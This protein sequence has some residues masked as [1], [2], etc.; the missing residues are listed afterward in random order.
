M[1]LTA[2]TI[3]GSVQTSVLGATAMNSR[4]RFCAALNHIE[5][6]R[7]PVDFGATSVTGMHVLAVTRLRLAVTGDGQYRVKVT[8]PYQMLGELDDVL[9]D[10]LEIDV[11]GLPT[12]KNMFGMENRGWKPFTL[13][14]GTEVLVPEDFNVRKDERGDL[15][16]FPE[17]DTNAPPS[18][19][20][21]K[22][23][24][25]FDT[26][27]RQPP[28]VE[29]RLDPNDN[30]EEFALISDQDLAW[31]TQLAE[32]LD[33][34]CRRGVILTMP[35]AAFGDIA[36]VPA[37]WMKHPKGIRDVAE[38]YIS[39]AIRRDYVLK[40]FEKQCEIALKNIE[41]LIA[42]LGD[43]VQAVM[44]TGTDFGT[45]H[46]LFLSIRDYRELFKPF[47]VRV[48]R[49]IHDRS[50]WKTF[51]HSCG[52][53][54]QLIPEFIEAGFDILN[55]VQCSATGMDAITLKREFGKQIVFWGGGVNTQ[56][57]MAF[58]TPDEVYREARQRIEIFGAGGGFVFNSV[59]NIQATTP[60]ENM[61]AMFRAIHD[62]GC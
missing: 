20:M 55:P 26:I 10:A 59:H 29:D 36:L 25:F 7:V 48:N 22:G 3:L 12:R 27:V 62:S 52:A 37:P 38:W 14:D 43:R 31:Y 16:I 46:G 58:G 1:F 32:T 53:V 39:T 11:T 18:G 28:I 15:L 61:L 57:T 54:V 51:I 9:L 23:F 5:P 35:G 56:R 41:T 40:V 24:Y 50:A 21:P 49:L 13:F 44:V 47:H 2:A 60:T 19:R 42:L 8:E 30:I 6:D 45:Q 34:R 33:Q 4:E 17:G